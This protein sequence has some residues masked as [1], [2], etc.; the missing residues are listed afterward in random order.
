MRGPSVY[1]RSCSLYAHHALH[2]SPGLKGTTDDRID[3][4][5]RAV[6]RDRAWPEAWQALRQRHLDAAAGI[7][8]VSQRSAVCDAL[9]A[10]FVGLRAQLDAL[11]VLGI[12][13]REVP[14]ALM[15]FGAVFSAQLWTASLP[16]S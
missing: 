2:P 7:Q 6:G 15:G 13:V 1:S 5:T 16:Y 4:A 3:L 10:G 8:D 11:A 9:D 12:A 14:D